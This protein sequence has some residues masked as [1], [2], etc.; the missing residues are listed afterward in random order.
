[1]QRVVATEPG[2]YFGLTGTAVSVKECQAN[3]RFS[4][5]L[6]VWIDLGLLRPAPV[7]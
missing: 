5:Q 7:D 4:A 3:V 1:M 2:L 6:Y